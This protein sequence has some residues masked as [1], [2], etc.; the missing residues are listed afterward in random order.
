MSVHL[1]EEVL[2]LAGAHEYFLCQGFQRREAF[3]LA[4]EDMLYVLHTFQIVLLHGTRQCCLFLAKEGMQEFFDQVDDTRQAPDGHQRIILLEFEKLLEH[5]PVGQID[6]EGVVADT[7]IACEY[8]QFGK[9]LLWKV[10][11]SEFVRTEDEQSSDRAARGDAYEGAVAGVGEEDVVAE[12][13]FI[14]DD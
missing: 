11:H 13:A 1:F 4:A 2:Q 5:G 10:L 12:G 14:A 3:E 6:E 9:D 7:V 8:R